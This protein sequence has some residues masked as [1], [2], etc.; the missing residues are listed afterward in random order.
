MRRSTHFG[1]AGLS[2]VILAAVGLSA[3]GQDRDPAGALGIDQVVWQK[4]TKDEKRAHVQSLTIAERRVLREALGIELDRS[5]RSS[6]AERAERRQ[7]LASLSEAEKEALRSFFWSS[8]SSPGHLRGEAMKAAKLDLTRA[9]RAYVRDVDRARRQES[10]L[11]RRD[12]MSPIR[13]GEPSPARAPRAIGTIQYDNNLAMGRFAAGGFKGNRFDTALTAMG[14][15]PSPV[16]ASGSVTQ[17]S[18]VLS[19]D[20]TTTGTN[21]STL[22]NATLRVLGPGTTTGMAVPLNT[23][24]NPAGV[25][26]VVTFGAPVNYVGPSFIVAFGDTPATTTTTTSTFTSMST[27]TTTSTTTTTTTTTMGAT[28]MMTNM[29]TMMSTTTFTST[30]TSTTNINNHVP[31]TSTGTVGGQGHHGVAVSGTNVVGVAG[32]NFLIRARGNVVVPVELME[33]AI[34]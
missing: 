9:Q 10:R 27:F 29:M 14:G 22:P 20:T 18:A 19:L 5:K 2:A 7:R 32:V 1:V 30:T 4:M 3:Q 33:F 13:R 21:T 6:A 31:A 23:T 17:V 26:Q 28:N 16:I 8:E 15:G 12:A 25:T 24:T 11:A 34:D